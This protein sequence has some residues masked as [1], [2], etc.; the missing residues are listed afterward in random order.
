LNATDLKSA[1][2]AAR[3]V[4]Y[5]ILQLH[6]LVFILHWRSRLQALKYVASWMPIISQPDC[7]NPWLMGAERTSAAPSPPTGALDAENSPNSEI[8]A[9]VR[10]KASKRFIKP[11]DSTIRPLEGNRH[12]N[13]AEDLGASSEQMSSQPD[14]F[15]NRF[16]TAVPDCLDIDL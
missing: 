8:T 12:P 3:T 1:G 5:P 14:I 9:K 4:A 6:S 13:M 10:N 16:W 2:V 11:R 7:A 15:E